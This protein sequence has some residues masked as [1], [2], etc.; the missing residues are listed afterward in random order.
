MAFFPISGN[1]WGN[2]LNFPELEVC[3]NPDPLKLIHLS[4]LPVPVWGILIGLG[5]WGWV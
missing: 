1:V 3:S 5:L 2:V 4:Q